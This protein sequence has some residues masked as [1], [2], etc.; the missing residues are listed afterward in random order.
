MPCDRR[1]SAPLVP[2]RL[3]MLVYFR[4]GARASAT[5]IIRTRHPCRKA[6]P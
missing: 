2:S 6:W 5:S 4:D 1:R 3:F